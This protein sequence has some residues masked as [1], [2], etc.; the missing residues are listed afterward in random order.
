MDPPFDVIL[1]NLPYIPTATVPTLPVA[2]S[3]EPRDALDGGAD[4]LSTIRELIARLRA[5]LAPDGVALLEIG[6]DQADAIRELVAAELPGWRTTVEADLSGAPR[7]VR[8]ERP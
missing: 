4:G 8:I 1:A 6:S 3:F 2:A 5:A 7:V